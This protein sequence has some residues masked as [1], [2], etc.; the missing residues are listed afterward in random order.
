L[1]DA[2]SNYSIITAPEGL[3]IGQM[4]GKELE[5]KGFQVKL[6]QKYDGSLFEIVRNN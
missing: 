5:E 4:T 2:K 6:D 1:I 3:K